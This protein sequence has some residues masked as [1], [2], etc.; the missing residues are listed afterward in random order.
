MTLKKSILV[1]SLFLLSSV[2]CI[3]L[4]LVFFGF[5]GGYFQVAAFVLSVTALILLNKIIKTQTKKEIL[6]TLKIIRVITIMILVLS[7]INTIQVVFGDISI[8]IAR[9]EGF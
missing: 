2:L 8:A 5:Y 3:A 9:L 4:S 7:G 6:I 1:F